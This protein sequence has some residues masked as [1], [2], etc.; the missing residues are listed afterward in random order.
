MKIVYLD[1]A[2]TTK[3]GEEVLK[4]MLPYF[5]EKFGNAS[6]QYSLGQEAR[7]AVENARKHI[8]A[9]INAEPEEIF[10]TSGG[11]E[12]DNSAL[13]GIAFRNPEKKHLITS[14]IEHPAVLQTCKWLEKRGYSVTYLKVDKE[15]IVNPADVEKAIKKDT[16]AVSIMHA[17]NEIGTTEPI[18][19]IAEICRKKNVIFHT[20]AVQ[21]FGKIPIDV[22]TM[23]IDML[24]ASSHKIY[25]PKGV[26]ILFKRKGLW[27]DALLNGG[28]QESGARSGTENVPGIVGFGKAAETAM[29]TMKEESEREAKLCDKL[30][31]GLLK[32]KKSRL[33]GHRT[34]R[35]PN[36]VN[37]SF[38]AVE[39]E[40]MLLMLNEKG[41]CASTG[42]ACSTGSLEPSHVLLAI[43]LTHGTAHGSLRLTLGKETTK[44]DV[45]YVL[46]A[47]PGIV[48]RLRKMS[49][50]WNG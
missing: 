17:N 29:K 20:D 15:G 4:E 32:I 3:A 39:G 22:K 19:E 12:S 37:I 23:K 50:L 38:E 2:A 5:S 31:T 7:Q 18:K 21:S 11:T 24:S 10:F 1:N 40:S 33:N 34:K 13:K 36:N 16:L 47:V 6:T 26:G 9:L 28:G 48:E 8:A 46:K 35:L 45:D 25:G 49:P 14:A 27:I 30:I 41:I 42:S 43:G 44:E